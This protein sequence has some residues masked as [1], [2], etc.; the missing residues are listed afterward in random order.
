MKRKHR[1]PGSRVQ[2]LLDEVL[3]IL[4]HVSSAGADL[5]RVRPLQISKLE[6]R[7]LMSASPMA[8]VAEVAVTTADIF[9]TD[10]LND[11][12]AANTAADEAGDS[13]GQDY[14]STQ[15]DNAGFGDSTAGDVS[16]TVAADGPELIVIDSRVQDADTLLAEL[17]SSDRDFRILRLDAAVDGIQ[18]ISDRLEELGHASAIHLLTHGEDGEILLGSSVLNLS[19]LSQYAPELQ[20]WQ[21]NLTN[22]ADLL[23]YGCDVAETATG[24]DFVDALA[25]LTATDAEASSDA[26]GA[27]ILGGNWNLEYSVGAINTSTAFRATVGQNWNDL[28][29]ITLTDKAEFRVNTTTGS[30]QVTV[31][32]ASGSHNAV[33][34]STDGT[35]V[36]VWASLNQDGDGW[37]VYARKYDS[38][39]TALTGEIRVNQTISDD[40]EQAS[41]GIDS[42]GRFTVVWTS[43]NQGADGDNGG[44][45]MRR[46]NSDGTAIDATDV[47]VNSGNTAGDQTSP[48]IAVN[49]SG[50][51]VISWQSIG[52]VDGVF[53]RTFTTTGSISGS[54]LSTSLISVD[55]GSNVDNPSVAINNSG[56]FVIAWEQGNKPHV[57]RFNADGSTR[58]SAININ[59]LNLLNAPETDPVVAM[60]S[61]GDFVAVYTSAISGFEGVWIRRYNDD[62]SAK[63]LATAVAT[64][65]QYFAP[66]VSI[67][68]D[69]SIAVTYVGN[70]ASG[71]GI[72][73]RT[74]SATGAA[75]LPQTAVNESTSGTQGMA[76]VAAATSASAVVVWS[77]N[78]TQ[79][80]NIDNSGVFVRQLN[81][82]APVLDLDA[83]NSSGSSGTDYSTTF[84]SGGAAVTIA[85]TDA[86]ISDLDSVNLQSLTVTITNLQN[87]S[88]EVLAANTSGTSITASYNSGILSLTGSDT[89][90]HYQQVLRTITYRNLQNPATGSSRTITFA[91]SDGSLTSNVATST[92]SIT[93][94]NAAPVITSNGGGATAAISIPENSTSVTTVTATDSDLPAQ[95]LTYSVSGGADAAKFTIDSSTGVISFAAAP[96]YESPTDS[97]SDNN[98]NVTVMV[99]DGSLTDTQSITVTV[100][101]VNELAI[102]NADSYAATEDQTLTVPV[103]SGVLANDTEP[104]G[105][106]ISVLD[107]TQAAHGTVS[108]SSNGAFTYTPVA[109]YNGSDTFS[110]VAI[111]STPGL[112]HY[113]KLDGTATDSAGTANGT[114]T[115]ATTVPGNL[116]SA[117]QFN[118]TSDFVQIPDFSYTNEF[119]VAFSFKV[120]DNSG[121]GY[122]YIYSHGAAYNAANALNVYLVE[123]GITDGSA[124]IL[125]T[126]FSDTNDDDNL[127]GLD[128][129][130]AIL[131]LIDNQWH[132]Y[133]LTVKAG[134][135]STV[136]I[137]GVARAQM[138]SGGDAMD[139]TGNLFLG[140]RADLDPNRFFNG[141]LDSVMFF[142]RT[143]SGSEVSTLNSGGTAKATVTINVASVNDPP[144]LATNSVLTL[145]EGTSSTIDTSHLRV[146]DI[147]NTASQVTYT[148]TVPPSHGSVTLNGSALNAGGTWTQADIDSNRLAYLHDGSE[149]TSDT[150]RF[151]VSDGFGGS[152]GTTTFN[153]TVTP[154][155]DAPVLTPG[156]PSLGTIAFNQAS[157]GHTVA[158]IAG[159]AI[160]DSDS[161]SQIGI[162]ITS[163]TGAGTWQ[164]SAG[165]NVWVNITGVSPTSAVLLLLQSDKIRYLASSQ[166]EVA[167]MTFVAWDQ[168]GATVGLE[169]TLFDISSIGT[170]GTAPFSLASDTI[171]ITVG[172]N[173]APVASGDSYT[174]AEDGTLSVNTTANWE[175]QAWTRR[176][177][178]TFNNSTGTTNLTDQVVLITLNASNIDYS[179]TQ[180]NGEDLRFFDASGQA[181]D[182]EIEL[183]DEVGTSRV[184]VR[185]PQVDAASNTDSIWM[186]YGNSSAPAG[187]N[188]AGVWPG[189]NAAVL[190]MNSTV[191]DSSVNGTAVTPT[192]LTAS[193]GIVAGAMT[194]DGTTSE[195]QF[196]SSSAL[197]NVFD[198]GGTVSAWINP[199]GWGENGYGRIADKASSTFGGGLPGNGWALQLT[200]SGRILFQ[201]GFTVGTGGW[202]TSAGTIAL[203]SWSQVTVVYDSSSTANMPKI[204]INGTQVAVTVNSSA[205]G[206]AG[207]DAGQKL[208]VG[209]YASATNRTFAGQIDEFRLNT[210]ALT[211]DQIRAEY[212]STASMFATIGVIETGPGGILAND[213]DSEFNPLQAVLS[214]GPAHA[215]SFTLNAD[216]SF[217][218]TP[219]AN[220]NGADSFT[221]TASDGALSSSPVTVTISVTPVN[222]APTFSVSAS[223]ITGRI[224]GAVAG[225][226][227]ASDVDAGDTVTVTSSDSRFEVVSNQLRLK[228][229]ISIDP[230]TETTVS[231]TLTATD[232]SGATATQTVTLNVTDPNTAASLSLSGVLNSIAENT[233]L[234]TN[235]KV[236][237]VVITDDGF[238]TNTLSLSGADAAR[239]VVVGTDLYL[240]SSTA[241]N[242]EA[243]SS[244]NVT[245]QLDDPSISGTPDATVAYT[246]S[247]LDVN[248]APSLAVTQIVSS[249]NENTVLT[250]N[251]K[252]A[253]LTVSDD[254]LGTNTLALS[255]PDAARFLISGS[256]LFIR[257]STIFDFEAKPSYS[258]AV[259]LNDATLPG[260]PFETRNFTFSVNNI[261][262]A[263]TAN[264]GGPYVISE[265][266]SLTVA[267]GTSVDPEG[268]PL[269]YAWDI[270]ND[271]AFDDAIGNSA[272]LSW[273]TL[274]SLSIPINDNGLRTIR[275]QVTDAGGNSTVAAASLTINNVAPNVS[276]TGN[277]TAFSGVPYTIGLVSSDPGA[278]TISTY[279]IN[280]G[281]GT[282]Q[283]IAGSLTSAI[284]TYQTPGGTRSISVTATDEDGTFSMAGGPLVVT[285]LNTAPMAPTLSDVVIPGLINGASVGS[286][287]FT[288]PDVGDSHIWSVSD[289]RFTVAGSTLKLKPSQ[290]IDPATEPTVTLT[291]T[292]TDAGGLSNS[293]TFTLRTNHLPVAAADAYA[294]DGTQQLSVSSPSLGVLAND[295]DGDNDPLT[296]S[297]VSG[298]SHAATF[299]LNA[300]GTFWYRAAAGFSGIDSFTYRATDGENVSTVTTVTFTVDRPAS[301]DYQAL[302]WNLPEHQ[303]LTS[304][305]QVGTVGIIDDGIG[306]N[307]VTLTGPDAALFELDAD[308]KLFLKSGLTID[309]SVQTQFEVTINLDDP[310]IAGSPDASQTLIFTVLDLNEP[311]TVTA[312]PDVVLLEDAP[313][314]TISTS[315]AFSDPNGDPLTYTVQVVSQ[316][317][318]LIQSI[319]IDSGTGVISYN[320]N[321]DA[322]GS[323]TVRVVASD[324]FAASVATQFQLIVQ[325]V[326]DAPVARGFSG[327]TFTDQSLSVSAPGVLA[328]ATDVDHDPI[329]V[330]LVSGPAHGTLVLNANGSFVY[331]PQA[332]F[333]GVDTFRYMASDG[334][335]SSNVGTATIDVVPLFAGIQNGSGNSNS[336]ANSNN[337]NN[338]NNST[339][340]GS[341]SSASGAGATSNSSGSA[342]T[343][344]SGAGNAAPNTTTSAGGTG[345]SGKDAL[346]VGMINPAMSGVQSS[347]GTKQDDDAMGFLPTTEGL[348][349][350][351]ILP[352]AGQGTAG[353]SERSDS[354]DFA[355][356]TSSGGSVHDFDATFNQLETN[357]SLASLNREREMLYRQIADSADSRSDS[358]TEQLERSAEL[359]GRVVGSVGVVTT[360]FSVG[361][362]FW[363]VRLGTLASGLLAQ[364]PAWS[365]L[366]PLLV[367]DGDQ[368]DDDK[369]SLQNIMDRQQAKLNKTEAD[370]LQA[371]H[372]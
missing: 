344:L 240:R 361:Y 201:Q 76:S 112:S 138:A 32:E 197:N 2:L 68:A 6:D 371:C 228:S 134:V 243:K 175:N 65:S 301:I 24:R 215:A 286:L 241:L 255:G 9:S 331:T 114:V 271:G 18:Q 268:Q 37:G 282:V 274:Q 43:R 358:V 263:P 191:V 223:T 31:G 101:N 250:S 1:K 213:Q 281:D 117:L 149:T 19:T 369:E 291:V 189:D 254:A 246:L 119:S 224:P 248:E 141:Q 235:L 239:F 91:A 165:A 234:A 99:S 283:D 275:V 210:N 180:N 277:A 136:Y 39:G 198:G 129:D 110:Y 285:V 75:V 317:P 287:S 349:V 109:N 218:Y 320:L 249:I 152:I 27:E 200:S 121:T 13:V 370:G 14:S 184:W 125:R 142:S 326:N 146:T 309:F 61:N 41:V 363:A 40:Q 153:I 21:D 167:T 211:A 55:T 315:F 33:A 140:A 7:I 366:D 11:A 20:A 222:D 206:L 288:D 115:G 173:T 276:L 100:T 330:T 343:A 168:T 62:G 139:P 360:G 338:S 293:S 154:Q 93:A 225:S 74:W 304:P 5:A 95:T 359:K 162:A 28:L 172:S 292:V 63:G 242:Y 313:V 120:A 356:R 357:G 258:V 236:A 190:H 151:T 334:I 71:T 260:G 98:Y 12:P 367:I 319:S 36:V 332:G 308:N 144:V 131:G 290:S 348:A 340:A 204:Y 280:W 122:Q 345:T 179:Q 267:A 322:F 94:S 325:P 269:T 296:A 132:Q 347:T 90:A 54:A 188:S 150:F 232:L 123:S 298:P 372:T 89:I 130:T 194:F 284:H 252:I 45:F 261:D 66:A 226:V 333:N 48:S 270:D 346:L 181:L 124:N 193:A 312:L 289:S 364:V 324:P 217:N 159:G 323:A 148:L 182:Y 272:T 30:T 368:K 59:P 253:D 128:V 49:S 339:Q 72:Y 111:D 262:E 259:V 70:D 247:V 321:P 294:I 4:G 161:G 297:L 102:A 314:G 362:L 108:V 186:Y 3:Y 107:Y 171:G 176:S 318:G 310:L 163:L 42:S 220:Y 81:L 335:L 156:S 58:G 208:T 278:D 199:T 266:D 244:Y 264:A 82:G 336:N 97:G 38:T 47:L 257:S 85:D 307:T 158:S 127:N 26:T 273:A 311:P 256:S 342:T 327:T 69:D 29:N 50:A 174:V 353:S 302:V 96:N 328:S 231:L 337:S 196:A 16:S 60:Q 34:L 341:G 237:T 192:A 53:A 87:G 86:T 145:N 164:Y 221:Y 92:V 8:M 118:G 245:V 187:Q 354:S 46:F 64:G 233:V 265:G 205:T 15:A 305:L 160:S 17:L 157:S 202:Q 103:A 207:S 35:Y 77:G 126:R 203:N 183:W 300:N 22:D 306:T 295:S 170:G 44:I 352:T 25:Q 105:Q 88:N 137:D 147:D 279:R 355:R 209:N 185:V 166:N 79:T 106:S 10:L 143:L 365:M 83:N 350:K 212:L 80:G 316:K 52:T 56:L 216:G 73:L 178:I 195:A 23:I 57:Q 351:R 214:S 303:T 155:N 67:G 116:G 227:S 135:G 229:G 251:L 219:I 230:T 329:T 78:G 84:I 51:G 299:G 177:K 133:V 169:H 104:D 238:G 113:W